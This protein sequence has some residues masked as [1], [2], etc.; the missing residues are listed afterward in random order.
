MVQTHSSLLEAG[1]H[2]LNISARKS[3]CYAARLAATEIVVGEQGF[4][5]SLIPIFSGGN[6][7]RRHSRG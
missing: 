5:C 6:L 7:R 3:A 4:W 2:N 1:P